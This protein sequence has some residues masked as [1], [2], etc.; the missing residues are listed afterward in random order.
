MAIK[1]EELN[2]EIENINEYFTDDN[3]LNLCSG[4]E[5]QTSFI[6]TTLAWKWAIASE[7]E[8]KILIVLFEQQHGVVPIKK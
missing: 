7:E 1:A 6:K 5:E 8:K 3:F 4:L 2:I